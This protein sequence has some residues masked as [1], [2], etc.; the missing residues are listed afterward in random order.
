MR[1]ALTEHLLSASTWLEE[2]FAMLFLFGILTLDT[3]L[4]AYERVGHL[5]AANENVTHV[6]APAVADTKSQRRE[7]A[8]GPS[9]E[10][11]RRAAMADDSLSFSP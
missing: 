7:K 8:P 9:I 5:V 3:M 11:V 2:S 6:R 10:Q 4:A 1:L